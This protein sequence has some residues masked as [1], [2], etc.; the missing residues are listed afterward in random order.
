MKSGADTAAK[1]SVAN[2]PQ[3]KSSSQKSEEKPFFASSSTPV[4]AK[5]KIG[6]PND[7]AE[8]EA[9]QMAD[10]V[11]RA[12]VTD[13]KKTADKDKKV[14][15]KAAPEKGP[16]KPPVKPSPAPE[17]PKPAAAKMDKVQMKAAPA[18]E[19][20]P[21]MKEAPPKDDKVQKKEA[22]PAKDE[23]AP[24]NT[25]PSK[26]DKVQKKEAAKD[27]KA[28]APAK[29][30]KIQ[31]K[32]AA[33][34]KDDKVQMN[35]APKEDKVQR[36]GE[37]TPSSAINDLGE[38][39]RQQSGGGHALSDDTKNFMEHR[40]NADF[41]NVR[42]H[43]GPDASKLSNEAGAKAFT[44]QNHIFFNQNEYQPGTSGGKQ[45]LA[46]ELTHVV[47]QGHSVQ[48]TE[49][50][51]APRVEPQVQRIELRIP[52]WQD[53]LDWM[54]EK[55]H[56]Y[57]P[58]FR[59]FTIVVGTNPITGAS[60]DTSAA[61][62]LRAIVEFLPGGGL[63]TQALEKYSVF[64]KAGSWVE[65]KL[66]KFSNLVSQI[67]NGINQFRSE[68]DLSDI[69]FSPGQTWDRAV[70]IFS[71]P[72][73]DVISFIKGLFEEIM[74]FIRDAVLKPLA[75]LAAKAPGFDLLCA[76][77]GFNPITNESVPRNA[78]TL[79][80]GFMKMIG[81]QDIWDNIKKGNAVDK[82]FAWFQKAMKGLMDMVK[83][84]PQDFIAML[85]SIEVMDFI[86][87]PN[88]FSKVFK[89]FGG[90]AASFADWAMNTIFDLLEI[91][92]SVVAPGAMP[93]LQK[94]RGAF[95]S[96]LEKPMV[97]VGH[98]VNAAKQGFN[99]F[100]NRFGTW[101]KKGLIDWL[102][103]S[104]KGA[105]IYI[106]QAFTLKEIIKL[107]LSVFGLTWQ[108]VRGKLVKAIGETAVVAME[109]GFDVVQTLVNEG[110]AAAWD[111]MQ[112]K[113]EEL[114]AQFIS[115]VTTYVTVTVVQ[116]A[117]VKLLSSLN[118]AGAFIQSIISIYNT[119]MFLVQKIQQIAQ[120]GMAVIDSMVEIAGGAIGK[121][122]N[123]VESVLG[124]MLSLAISF[125][126]NFLGLGKISD[127]V[128]TIIKKL[129]APVDKAIDKVIDW[130]VKV[131]KKFLAKAKEK[132]MGWLKI[133][134]TFTGGDQKSHSVYFKGK[135]ESAEIY[136]A[137]TPTLANDY[138]TRL[139]GLDP[140]NVGPVNTAR[141]ILSKI[142]QIKRTPADTPPEAAKKQADLDTQ[143]T[144]LAGVLSQLKGTDNLKDKMD[145]V[146]LT[147]VKNPAHPA[148]EFQHQLKMQEVA[149]NNMKIANWLANRYNF[150]KLGRDTPGL[151]RGKRMERQKLLSK[152]LKESY[153]ELKITS[154]TLKPP[155]LDI[156]AKSMAESK[157]DAFLSGKA[158]LHE[159]DQVAGGEGDKF[160]GHGAT[161]VNSS[162]G[163][164]W[165]TQVP[166]IVQGVEKVK[167]AK[168]SSENVKIKIN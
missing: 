142:G 147:F 64:E 143:F 150:E 45:L 99:Q 38:G 103:G 66:K 88:L 124:G 50:P 156:K 19:E 91:I 82:A 152:Y 161:N 101:L 93:Y 157:T 26:E 78:D 68:L 30:D 146:A 100:K 34:A 94:V 89:V 14:Q 140:A 168:H 70:S 43:S 127:K 25:A 40:F 153:D 79:I 148:G 104:L 154:P 47:Q 120:V 76:V 5:L 106:P 137:S 21:A 6:A 80:G 41:S 58:G 85:K 162:L 18:Q 115:E 75:A 7:P 81:R 125:L 57:V 128:V 111:K 63:I 144:L 52:S 15:T 33:P 135:D 13:G 166:L 42:I 39:I 29:E 55:A 96:I 95:K 165:K 74:Q 10:K 54:S 20:K 4:Q 132:L 167:P 46:H 118:P 155:A 53:A 126:A 108:N 27:E 31:K 122:A 8:K 36:K 12:P 138:L 37:G 32:E 51:A 77:I 164:Q 69:I 16:K 160:G 141:G 17:Q 62:I 163:S 22:P 107:G 86:I 131:G 90:F 110:P 113:I 60:V 84:F 98:L 73:N 9:D 3:K 134:K 1:T 23:K 35:A 72:V 102:L 44:Y 24:V 11:M 116:A 151:D 129:R 83:S 105:N 145:V 158:L 67:I 123:K 97:F 149:I 48:R 109:A 112:D 65:G 59:M 114:K 121:A 2:P 87:L 130:V 61:N 133:R 49:A 117:I 92:F 28:P 139:Q 119:I 71:T 159:V 56:T 136:I